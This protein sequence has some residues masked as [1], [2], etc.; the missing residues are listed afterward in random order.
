MLN[1]Q[2][3]QRFQTDASR[4]QHAV[5]IGPGLHLRPDACCA[6]KEAAG[7]E[8]VVRLALKTLGEVNLGPLDKLLAFVKEHVAPLMATGDTVG[9]RRAAALASARVLRRHVAANMPKTG[10]QSTKDTAITPAF[11]AVSGPILTPHLPPPPPPPPATSSVCPC[12]A[13]KLPLLALAPESSS[14]CQSRFSLQLH[15]TLHSGLRRSECS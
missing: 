15:A 5:L 7:D 8:A 3:R 9:L 10:H 11:V 2:A 6:D 1:H 14:A 4:G 12:H 13:Q